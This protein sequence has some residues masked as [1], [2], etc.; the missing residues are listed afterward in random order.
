MRRCI[1]VWLALLLTT[2]AAAQESETKPA[3]DPSSVNA[4]KAAEFAANEA[5]R[6]D[7]RHASGRGEQFDLIEQPALRWS[8][9]TDGEVYGSVV[10]WASD[11]CP[12]AAASIYQFFDR[13]QI[14]IELVSLSESPLNAVRNGRLRWSPEA[15]V[16]FSS[17]PGGPPPAQ[18]AERRQLQMRSLARKFTGALADRGND[19]TFS[20]L[21]LMARPLHS[22]SNSDGTRDGAVFALVNTTDPEILLIIESRETAGGREWMYGAARMH[23][24]RVQLKLGDK[25]VWEAPQAAPPWDKLRGP[26]GNYVI[27]E[28]KTK[29][30]AAAD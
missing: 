21:R 6:Y 27:L 24:C 2:T 7:I 14:N 15:G 17:L 13:D 26:E 30:Q 11:G 12:E 28:W 18:S 25:I 16:V 4:T 29:E 5:K 3:P 9:P 8:N 20:E 19:E 1:L 10:L 23:F 22:Y